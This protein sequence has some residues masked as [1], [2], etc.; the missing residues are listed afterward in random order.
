[1]ARFRPIRS[2][3]RLPESNSERPA[4]RRIAGGGAF[5]VKEIQGFLP[6]EETEALEAAGLQG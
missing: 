6:H 5:F 3:R 4:G 1:M 2:E